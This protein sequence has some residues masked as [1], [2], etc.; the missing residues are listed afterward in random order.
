MILWAANK[1]L[2]GIAELTDFSFD[3]VEK[4]LYAQ[5]I[6]SGEEE[7]V[8]VFLED[9]SIVTTDENVYKLSIQY[10]KSNKP[11][12]DVFLNKIVLSREWKIPDSQ[13]ELVQELILQEELTVEE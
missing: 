3:S 4:K 8:D 2:R 13:I 9:F 7:S 6:L 12:L 11:W 10:V 5:M 1:K